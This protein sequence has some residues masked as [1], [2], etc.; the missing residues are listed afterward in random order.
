MIR[1]HSLLKDDVPHLSIIIWVC[2]GLLMKKEAV[3]CVLC[4]AFILHIAVGLGGDPFYLVGN[5]VLG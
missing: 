1:A 2:S 5:R 3:W 4:V